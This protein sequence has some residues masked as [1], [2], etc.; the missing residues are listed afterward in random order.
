MERNGLY[1][2]LP[3]LVMIFALLCSVFFLTEL[4]A[5]FCYVI[6]ITDIWS[7]NITNKGVKLLCQK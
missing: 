6:I 3:Y 7:V 4:T 2:F 5:F 1:W